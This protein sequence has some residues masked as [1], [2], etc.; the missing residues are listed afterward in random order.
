MINK[1]KKGVIG[2]IFS[3]DRAQVLLTKRNDIPIWVLPG[4]SVEPNEST[5]QAA[6]R[7]MEEETGYHTEPVRKIAKYTLT[8]LFIHDI[9][10]YEF[11]ILSGQPTL[12]NETQDIQFF[13]LHAIPPKTF[14]PHIDWIK[15]AIPVHSHTLK[16]E[17]SV[18]HMLL[19]F[20]ILHPILSAR[21][22]YIN[23]KHIFML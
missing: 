6:T 4:G 1:Q 2:I 15:D 21:Y 13:P 8:G 18:T 22:V 10:F 14:P 11:H 20:L 9:H 5:K 23:F 3:K 12:S 16:K 17:V 19:K 7:E